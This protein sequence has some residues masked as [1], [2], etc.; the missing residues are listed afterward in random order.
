[1][2]NNCWDNLT[3][4]AFCMTSSQLTLPSLNLNSGC[5]GHHL[6]VTRS[7]CCHHIPVKYLDFAIS[8]PS[9]NYYSPKPLIVSNYILDLL[10]CFKIY[11]FETVTDSRNYMMLQNSSNRHGAINSICTKLTV[12]CPLTFHRTSADRKEGSRENKNNIC[13]ISIAACAKTMKWR[14]KSHVFKL[15]QLYTEICINH[16]CNLYAFQK[17]HIW[18][19][20]P[21]PYFQLWLERGW[22][23]RLAI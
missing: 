10:L 9:H 3:Y 23:W 7:F 11:G 1:M 2:S 12:L 8:W 21:V 6:K 19:I 20:I 4:H 14:K 22:L 17:S 16:S 15:S 18:V 13:I 5:T